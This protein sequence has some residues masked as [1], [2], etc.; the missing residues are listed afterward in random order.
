MRRMNKQES[1]FETLKDYNDYLETVEEITWNLILKIDVENTERRLRLWEETQKAE[2]DPNA[3][4]RLAEPDPSL[5][6]DTSHVVL[7]KG[8][9]QRKALAASSGNTP[10][11]FGT[12]DDADKDAGFVFHGLKKYVPPEPEKPFNPFGGWGIEPKYYVFQK[13]YDVDWLTRQKNDPGHLVGGY[14]MQDFY[15]RCL[16]E[17]F[18]GLGIFIEDEII[19]RENQASGDAGVGTRSAATAAAGGK[20][21]DMSDVF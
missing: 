1:D 11:P 17:A 5:P 6:S 19:A 3:P 8:A 9:T 10:D 12:S 2:R 16:R 13:D 4:R 15:S 7:K 18:G 20:D 14:D 21:V